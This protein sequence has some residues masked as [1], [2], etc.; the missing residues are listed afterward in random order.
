MNEEEE[1]MNIYELITKKIIEE[2]EK[3][4]IPWRKPWISDTPKNLI[5]KKEYRGINRLLLSTISNKFNNP[6][7]ATF[8]QIDEIGG[9]VKKGEKGHIVVF[10]KV[11]NNDEIEEKEEI[12][13]NDKHFVLRYY[14]VFNLEQCWIPEEKKPKNEINNNVFEI[15]KCEN[16]INNMPKKPVIK[17]EYNQAF[18]NFDS[19]YIGIPSKEKFISM[20]NFYSTLFHELVHSTGHETRLNRKMVGKYGNKE[21]YSK[22]ELI[23]EIGASFLNDIAGIRNV[24]FNN[25]IAYINSWLKVLKNDKRLIVMASN[26]AQ[27]AVDFIL[28]EKE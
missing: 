1:K 6:Y 2:L 22:E 3:G 12:E 8:K 10:W 24:N 16:I 19:D 27:K 26:Q 17:Y 9:Y 4:I 20:E 11:F 25:S 28:D 21:I 7:F 18:Y 14:T 15:E 5:T 23:A 13:K